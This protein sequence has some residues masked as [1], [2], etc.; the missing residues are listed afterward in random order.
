MSLTRDEILNN[1]PPLPEVKLDVPEWG[2]QVRIRTMKAKDRAQLEHM[3]TQRKD[4]YRGLKERLVIMTVLNGD[5]GLM[6][7]EADFTALGEQ[8]SKVID[9]IASV[10][11]ELNGMT[12]KDAED[13]VGNLSSDPS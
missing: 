6:F 7:T 9:R 10:A 2:G 12:D 13:L 1:P 8:S 3:A 11:M 5:G 4:D